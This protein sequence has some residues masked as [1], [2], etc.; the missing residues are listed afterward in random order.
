[1][2]IFVAYTVFQR[3]FYEWLIVYL[4]KTYAT[5]DCGCFLLNHYNNEQK[6]LSSDNFCLWV[7]SGPRLP[8]AL[9]AENPKPL[10]PSSFSCQWI[11]SQKLGKLSSSVSWVTYFNTWRKKATLI[12]KQRGEEGIIPKWILTPTRWKSG[13]YVDWIRLV[14]NAD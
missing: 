2:L 10:L 7:T 13:L 9:P 12:S 4:E 1:M 8:M 11:I 5:T 3:L 6:H 14:Q